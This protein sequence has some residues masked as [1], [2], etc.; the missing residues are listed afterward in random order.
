MLS[1][2]TVSGACPRLLLL[3]AFSALAITPARA[4][5]TTYSDSATF[6]S[7][8][9]SS[10]TDNYSNPGYS[11]AGAANGFVAGQIYEYTD[12]Y[13]DSVLGET[14]YVTTEFADSNLVFTA[15]GIAGGPG[16]CAGCNGS[17]DLIF[18]STTVGTSAGVYGAG[19]EVLYNSLFY[20]FV[21]FGDG[22]TASYAL[23]STDD[24]F[25]GITSDLDIKSIDIGASD[26]TATA[27]GETAITD[28]TIGSQ[29]APTPELSTSV[30]WL[31]GI[32]L[33]IVTRKRIAQRLR[34]G[35]VED[36]RSQ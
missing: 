21:T 30:L 8:L 18:T 31:T 7:Q 35:Y 14:Q 11:N 16:Y 36:A 15:S 22:S 24:S 27:D 20:A 2:V 17:F 9:G 10:V 33:M 23:P 5:T 29:S 1:G 26:G 28:L 34:L 19:F 4:T 3:F 12:A 32:G 6:M 13:M 25:W